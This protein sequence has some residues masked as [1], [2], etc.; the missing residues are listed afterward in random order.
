MERGMFRVTFEE[1]YVRGFLGIE[2][3]DY[4]EGNLFFDDKTVVGSLRLPSVKER[5]VKGDFVQ[6]N[7]DRE[8]SVYLDMDNRQEFS[9]FPITFEFDLTKEPVT[10]KPARINGGNVVMKLYPTT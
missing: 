2:I 7:D 1:H 9:A 8:L 6:K 5:F 3:R 4:G 10:S